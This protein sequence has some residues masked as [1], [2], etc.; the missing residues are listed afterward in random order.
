MGPRSPYGDTDTV[1]SGYVPRYMLLTPHHIILCVLHGSGH[2]AKYY[3]STGGNF[4]CYGKPV[5]ED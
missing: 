1:S 5:G 4:S 2:R 3:P